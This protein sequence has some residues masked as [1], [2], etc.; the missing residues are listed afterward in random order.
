MPVDPTGADLKRFLAE[1]SGGPVV[2]LNLL[3]FKSGGR[4]SYERYV[5]DIRRFLD[6]YRAQVLYAGDCST[7]L[8][9]PEQHE[10]DAVLV[11]EYPNRQAFSR[12]VA[13]PEYQKITRL[14]TDAL[15]EA[16]LQA[17]IPWPP[18]GR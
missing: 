18:S 12:M 2:M 8:V 3:R 10:W 6:R 7:V 13:D 1:D 14:R 4:G 11:V 9:A 17:T 15:S 5:T 16:V